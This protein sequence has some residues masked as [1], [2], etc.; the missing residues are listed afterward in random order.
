MKKLKFAGNLPE[1]ILSGEKN[2]TWRIEDDKNLCVGDEILLIR[3]SD[4]SQFAVAVLVDVVEKKF[5]ELDDCDWDGH[6]K[7][8]SDIEMYKTYSN[9]YSKEIGPDSKVKIIKFDLKI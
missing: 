4:L 1:L 7:F 6:E 9:Y 8:S 2:T 3:V 5:Y